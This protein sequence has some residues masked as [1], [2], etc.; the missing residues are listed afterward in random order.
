MAEDDNGDTRLHIAALGV[1]LSTVCIPMECD[2]NTKE[3]NG[4]ILLHYAAHGGHIEIVRKLVRDY[5]CD[6]MSGD[7]NGDTPLHLA[8]LGGSL[9]AVCTLIDEFKCDPN[10][11]GFEER[12]P[13]VG[14]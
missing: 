10:V 1:S 11:K 7:K 9:S 8:A 4:R 13:F 5:G 2:P 12:I 3:F 6:V 14:L